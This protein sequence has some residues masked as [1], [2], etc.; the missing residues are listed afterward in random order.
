MMLQNLILDRIWLHPYF[1]LCI[2]SSSDKCFLSSRLW[3]EILTHKTSPATFQCDCS[4]CETD[5]QVTFSFACWMLKKAMDTV[6][7]Y[8]VWN[9]QSFEKK[10]VIE[11]W[12]K[13]EKSHHR[14]DVSQR[15][16]ADSHNIYKDVFYLDEI[17]LSS[18]S[19]QVYPSADFV[20]C[21]LLNAS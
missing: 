10:I 16:Q 11:I 13:K 17:L 8:L 19:K 21:H 12:K 6:R 7:L 14:A 3:G 4:F 9:K 1:S 15:N 5:L 20:K 2:S 18:Y